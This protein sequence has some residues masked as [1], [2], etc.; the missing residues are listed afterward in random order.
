MS[1]YDVNNMDQRQAS[2][3]FAYGF[4]HSDD[5]VQFFIDFTTGELFSADTADHAED[6][7]WHGTRFGQEM[8][9]RTRDGRWYS[10]RCEYHGKEETT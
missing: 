2:A 9:L 3:E 4:L 6:P 5:P 1:N 8:I 10:L 7:E